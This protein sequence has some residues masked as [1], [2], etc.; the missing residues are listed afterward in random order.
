MNRYFPATAQPQ[1]APTL[2]SAV[3]DAQKIAGRYESSRRV[4]HGFLSVFYLLQQLVITAD[5]DGT[6]RVPRNLE[7]GEASFHEI[8]PDLWH[9]IGGNRQLA[10]RE[11]NGI[12]TVIDSEDPTSVLQAVPLSRS[13]ALNLTVML[14]SIVI[15]ALTV[16]LWLIS[17]LV[18]RRYRAPAEVPEVQ[19]LR[20]WLRIAV[21]VEVLYV[22][23]WIM[24]LTPVLNLELWVYSA[25]HDALVRTLQIAGLLAIAA[26]AVGIW[27]LW[28]LSRLQPSLFAWLRNATL[29]AA[30]LG[31]VWIGFV[32]RLFSFSLNY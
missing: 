20:R 25:E 12:K 16:M 13:A 17:W 14:G 8:A 9:E 29:A 30:L 22:V 1:E 28:R 5:A 21:I 18:R 32:G 19:R 26:A 7:P 15:L 3:Q 6:I 31:I 24:L 23:A 27:C 2:E 4:E 10:L 11:V